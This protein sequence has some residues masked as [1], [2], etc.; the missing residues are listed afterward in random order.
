MGRWFGLLVG[1]VVGCGGDVTPDPG[2]GAS[3]AGTP[4]V[5]QMEGT[6][7]G[8]LDDW[9]RDIEAGLPVMGDVVSDWRATQRSAVQ[10]YVERQEYIEMYWGPSGRLQGEG[11]APLAASVAGLETA[12]HEFMQA[13]M[14][15]PLDTARVR[16]AMDTM[17]VRI[18][19]VRSRG[20]E[21][22]LPLLPPGNTAR[23]GG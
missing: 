15:Q 10:L 16:S 3:V 1:V 18:A 11:G 2:A 7:A 4:E 6:P 23:S 19:D 14:A 21:S 5:G 9:L 17:R 12:F 8:G 13:L 20:V 22:G